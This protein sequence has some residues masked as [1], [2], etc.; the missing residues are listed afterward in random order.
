MSELIQALA[1]L[2]ATIRH[3][4]L[5]SAALFAV[6]FFFEWRQGSDPR[7][8]LSRNFLNDVGYMLF[9]QG[10]VYQFLLFAPL[11]GI[12]QARLSFF[13]VG[14]I[15]GL[16]IPGPAKYVLYWLMLDFIAYWLH[17][18]QH[19][20]HWLWA[21]H[22]I[23]HTQTRPTLLT[24]YRNHLLDQLSSGLM[25]AVPLLILGIPPS[26][27][28]PF[29]AL[30]YLSES[31]QHSELNWRYGPL[32][33]VIV[34]P[35]FHAFH[36]STDPAHYNRNYGKMLSLWDHVFRTAVSGPRPE[37]YGVEGLV[38]PE[39]LTSQFLAPFRILLRGAGPAGRPQP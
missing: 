25:M 20:N 30:Q 12:V 33:G 11:L 24:T 7:R 1:P 38:V 19:H 16:A 13:R 9:Y 3:A 15:E 8:Y 32:Y 23:H 10:G 5:L 31:A 14:I 35:V 34:S 18:F 4:L 36:H 2:L 28:L 22:S 17:R 21:F 26:V 39:T 6:I 37:R 29:Y 27:W